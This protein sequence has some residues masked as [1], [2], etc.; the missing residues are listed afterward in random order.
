MSIPTQQT[1][2]PSKPEEHA[3]WA[4]VNM[5]ANAGAPLILPEPVLRSWSA[6]LWRCGFRHH[7]ELQEIDYQPPAEDASVLEAGAGRWVDREGEHG[8]E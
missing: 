4:L 3:L 7:P 8:E 5:G 6:H 2:D 1:I